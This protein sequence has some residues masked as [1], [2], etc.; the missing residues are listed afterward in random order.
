MHNNEHIPELELEQ[1]ESQE[2]IIATEE[3]AYREIEEVEKFELYEQEF[4]R[5][6]CVGVR[7]TL[8]NPNSEIAKLIAQMIDEY[9]RTVFHIINDPNEPQPRNPRRRR[10]GPQVKSRLYYTV[11]L[12][13]IYDIAKNKRRELIERA[14]EIA[15]R[16][17]EVLRNILELYKNGKF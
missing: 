13:E 17:R 6:L 9:L 2:Q 11:T 12:P 16:H 7:V 5:D 10:K 15:Q 14:R 8:Y 1:T 4:D 3:E